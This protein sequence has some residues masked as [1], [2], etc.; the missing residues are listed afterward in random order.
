MPEFELPR[1]LAITDR[2]GQA[3]QNLFVGNL[4]GAWKSIF[5]PKEL[6]LVERDQLLKKWGL[7]DGPYARVFKTITNPVLLIALAM[8]HIFPIAAGANIFKLSK[9]VQSL[10]AKFPVLRSIASMQTLFQGVKRSGSNVDFVDEFGAIIKDMNDFRNKYG[11]AYAE[12]LA[13]FQKATGKLPSLREQ[14]QVS[15]WLDGLHKPLRGFGGKNGKIR[16]G[17]GETVATLDAIGTLMPNLEGHMGRPLLDLAKGFRRTMD[18]QWKEVFSDVK[19]RKRLLEAIKRQRLAGMADET[20]E[21]MEAFLRDPKKIP[22][23]FPR[24][25]LQS[26]EDF[27]RITALLTES[28]SQKKFAKSA[29]KKIQQWATPETYKR[30]FQML[31]DIADLEMVKDLVDPD[32]LAKL[33]TLIKAKMIHGARIAGVRGSTIAKMQETPLKELEE[34][35]VTMFQPAEAEKLAFVFQEVK[36]R[37]YSLKLM[38]V[39]AQYNHTLAG[40]NA[41][42]IKGGGEKVSQMITD[43]KF[44]GKTD[45]VARYQADIMENTYVPIAM[46]RG[47]FR[48]SLKAQMYAQASQQVAVFAETSPFVKKVLGATLHKQ[49]VAG[50]HSSKGAFNFMNLNR[51]VAGYFYLSTLG[52]N[53]G[54]ALKNTLQLILTTG[55]VIGYRTTAAGLSEAYRK[56]HKYFAQRLGPRKLTHE[57][58]L[59]V[60]YPEFAET[61][62]V[63][64]P[65]TEEVIQSSL[66]N[67]YGIAALPTKAVSTGDK[68]QRAMM[69]MFTASET[70]VRLAT[71]E[72]GMIHARRAKM[73]IE[74]AIEFSRKLVE[75]TQF[76][77]GP[78]NTPFFLL[79]KS[80]VVRQLTQFP[81]RMLEFATTTAMSLGSG[82]I[83]PRTGKEMNLLGINPG[84]FARMIAGSILTMELG[85]AM[86]LSLGDA[87][88]GGAV[89]TFNASSKVLAPIPVVPPFFQI[90]GAAGIGIGGGDYTE[91]LRAT[92]LLIPGGV[93]I[94]RAMGLVPPGVPGADL[95]KAAARTFRRTYADYDAPAPDGRIAVYSG[96]GTLKGY[97]RPWELVKYGMGVKGGDIQKEQE[98]LNTLVTQRDNIREEKAAYMEARFR[99]DAAGASRIKENFVQRFGF[100]LPVTQKDMEAMQVRRQVTRLE[101]VI[102]TLPPGR[103]REQMVQMIAATLGSQGA[104]LIGIDPELLGANSKVRQASR[105]AN[106][107][108]PRFNARKLSPFNE[109]NPQTIGRQKGINQQQPPF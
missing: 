49:V 64:S 51:K 21:A 106:I 25:I 82:A 87:L 22:D 11:S 109:V 88:I 34:K 50:L 74:A 2:P 54:S 44:R 41:W 16:I 57:Q 69:A 45:A 84:T 29:G 77:T 33:D 56:S 95:G 58:A 75:K 98:L 18:D 43:L 102:R 76:L 27:R 65:I 26:D 39:V 31:P 80:P 108:S 78:Q 99:N 19:G 53:P 59:R 37:Q 62:L 4:P 14:I 89:P 32:Q 63:A 70:T 1:E 97:Y 42:T 92:P 40:T 72:A 30:K 23:Y 60:A 52:L 9:R 6:T 96:R 104:A 8:S 7:N 10:G 79:D 71:F 93:A 36:P 24:R 66:Q 90:L 103:A 73:P 17:S 46:G 81:L 107:G 105:T 3:A 5:Q 94:S 28:A 55:P 48:Q 67:A 83:N 47:T 35:Y 68:I 13:A 91:L 61:G 20:S 15:A 86:N 38:P 101:Q 100:D 85:D 12:S